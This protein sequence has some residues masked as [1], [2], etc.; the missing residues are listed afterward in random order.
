MNIT[1]RE[2]KQEK[3]LITG[4]QLSHLW[5]KIDI[6]FCTLPETPN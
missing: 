5:H 1:G 4:G 6:K 3:C 2:D